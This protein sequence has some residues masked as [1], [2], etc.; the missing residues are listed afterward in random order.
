M[1]ET[2]SV[3]AFISVQV[4]DEEV[5]FNVDQI[6]AVLPGG[7]LAQSFIYTRGRA[8]PWKVTN[9]PGEIRTRMM[10]RYRTGPSAADDA[11]TARLASGTGVRR[12]PS[13]RRTAESRPCA[14]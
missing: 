6:V 3:M 10:R 12:V 4:R 2:S 14:C 9:F 7:D 5:H 8:E 11:L 13:S 1:T